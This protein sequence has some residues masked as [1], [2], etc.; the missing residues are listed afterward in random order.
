[1]EGERKKRE[2]GSCVTTER[3]QVQESV[4]SS[5]VEEWMNREE[6]KK[7]AS[8]PILLLGIENAGKSTFLTQFKHFA[9]MDIFRQHSKEEWIKR[10]RLNVIQTLTE[11]VDRC[12][13]EKEKEIGL[14]KQWMKEEKYEQV[15]Q[16]PTIQNYYSHHRTSSCYVWTNED[17]IPL[18]KRIA[19]LF[20]PD[21]QPI[22]EDILCLRQPSRGI[23]QSVIPLPNKP[24]TPLVFI[25][26]AG[27][28]NKRSKWFHIL[29]SEIQ[30]C[31]YIV[32]LSDFDRLDDTYETKLNESLC[33][34][35]Q[36]CAERWMDQ[37]TTILLF[38]KMDLFQEKLRKN[39]FATFFPD[40]KGVTDNVE[41]TTKYLETLFLSCCPV[42]MTVYTY[43]TCAIDTTSTHLVCSALAYTAF[44]HSLRSVKLL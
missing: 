11:I 5:Q 4:R 39:T 19:I 27:Q 35:R 10:I 17:A 2:M 18:L 31:V 37:K 30:M 44:S 32:S 21:Y 33:V 28:R 1:V 16:L 22:L 24:Q 9:Q 14:A 23:E 20:H 42:Q 15:W 7:M 34:F 12:G 43:W 41:Q 38:N 8:H 29:S 3:G 13:D 40:Y 26:V 6:Q 25:D 36:I